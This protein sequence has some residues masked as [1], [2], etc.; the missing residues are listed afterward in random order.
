M[1]SF[2]YPMLLFRIH[3]II[4][5]SKQDITERRA[6][7]ALSESLLFEKA[8]NFLIVQYILRFIELELLY[9]YFQMRM[10]KWGFGVF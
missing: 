7:N 4:C 1:R 2:E 8:C 9:F 6:E 3:L 10:L 5:E